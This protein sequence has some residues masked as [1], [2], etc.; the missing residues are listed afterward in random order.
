MSGIYN[1]GLRSLMAYEAAMNVTSQNIANVNTPYYSRKEVDFV[2]GLFQSG[3]SISDVNRIYDASLSSNVQQST[4]NY[5]QMDSLLTQLKSFEPML[6]DDKNSI[7]TYI[8]SAMAALKQMDSDTSSVQ[9]RAAYLQQ[10]SILI[11]QFGTVNGQISTQQNN[12]NQSMQNYADNSNTILQS[13]ASL[14]QQIA[15]APFGSDTSTL[16]DQRE[17]QVQALAKYMNFSTQVDS[18][19]EINL[20]LTNG[21]PL[22]QDSVA[23]S[24]TTMT[25]PANPANIDLALNNGTSNV[26]VDAYITSGQIAGTLTF[27]DTLAQA[28]RAIGQLSLAFSQ[29]MNA[30]NKSG[31]DYN[32]NLGGNIFNDINSP[33]L[34]N[35]RVVSNTNNKGSINST[36]SINDVTKLTSSDYT[37]KIDAANHYTLTRNS[38]GSVVSSGA[39][40]STF[41]Q[42]VTADGFTINITA[43]NAQ[44]GDSYTI[45]PTR[46]A[47]A[48]MGLAIT[49]PRLLALALPIVADAST[50]NQGTGSV[51]V[52]G[53]T[54]T[55][56][57]A[58]STSGQ[59][60]PPVT[61]KFLSATSY[62]LVNA[63]DNSVMEGPITYN[64]ATGANIFPTPGGYDPGYRVSLS[65]GISA[66][67]TFNINFNVNSSGDN[68]NGLLME[69]LYN[70]GV[71]ENGSLSFI[72]GYR[73]LSSDVSIQ[74]SAAA[75]GYTSTKTIR[76]QAQAQFDQLSAVS[77]Q[78]ETVNLAS[79]QQA[80]QASAQ[81]LSTA[82]AVFEEVMQMMES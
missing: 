28:Q 37:M 14:N 62:E 26:P 69:N 67:D 6:D 30:Q 49:D 51:Q 72:Q 55:T 41:P 57:S 8:N 22:V 16:L 24:L 46:G 20:T 11:N 5:E 81:I 64:P 61:I 52:T 42:A 74:T 18:R 2:E 43:A 39:V 10:L 56:N 58:F 73:M 4:S 36:V 79:Y 9:G 34:I 27:R 1:I 53:I 40:S 59:L 35:D 77:L 63:S 23:Y 12:I 31:L 80:Y 82:K 68:R 29:T 75:S 78:E 50:Q 15:N 21:M 38:D 65:G 45:S 60:S 71:M 19:G 48:N 3:V 70:Q 66:G 54:D 33:L 76:E 17:Q 32:G 47:T 7:A 25:D 13:I 44:V